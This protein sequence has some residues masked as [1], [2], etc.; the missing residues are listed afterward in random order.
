MKSVLENRIKRPH[1]NKHILAQICTISIFK[2]LTGKYDHD[3]V[4]VVLFNEVISENN[5]EYYGTFLFLSGTRTESGEL[6]NGEG[7]VS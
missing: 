7:G 6:R 1:P 3:C 5:I 2:R 4:V